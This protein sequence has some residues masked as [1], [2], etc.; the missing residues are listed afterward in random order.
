MGTVVELLCKT[1]VLKNNVKNK[2]DGL[3]RHI[4][5][6]KESQLRGVQPHNDYI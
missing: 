6:I 4:S 1:V 5:V 2:V 3:V